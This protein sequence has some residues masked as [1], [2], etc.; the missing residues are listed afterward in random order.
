[1]QGV[2]PLRLKRETYRLTLISHSR[3][4]AHVWVD[5]G[6]SHLDGL[7]S[8]RIPDDVVESIRVGSRVKVPFNS[9]S[10]EGLVVN[11]EESDDPQTNLKLIE[12]L[13]GH[14]PV[15]NSSIINFYARMSKYWG[16][17][18]YSLIRAGI[19]SRVASVEKNFAQYTEPLEM[20]RNRIR[21]K[22]DKAFLMHKPHFSAYLELADLACGRIKNGSVLLLL[23]DVKDVE[24]ILEILKYRNVDAPIIR[25]D[26]SL[27]RS[28]RYQNYLSV[29]VAE[30]SLVVGTR[31]ALFAPANNL[32][33]IIVG[34]EK[35]EQYFEQKHPYW[36]ARD[37]A[38]LRAEVESSNIYFTGYVPSAEVAYQIE[39]RSTAF[40]RVKSSVKTFAYSQE[41]GELLPDR[42]INKI[43]Q[44]LS[45][46]K[47]LFLAPRK[48][49]ANALLCSKCKN[50]SLCKCGGRLIIQGTN[51]DPVCS[52]CS[53]KIV[54]WM[55]SWCSGKTKYAVARGIDRFHEEIGRAFPNTAIQISS[56]P[57]ILQE[58]SSKTKIVISTVGSIPGSFVDY[59]AVVILE[60]QRFLA[61][62]SSAYEEMVFESFFEASSRVKKNGSVLI[63]LDPYHPAIAA[64]SRWNPSILIKKILRECSD[65]FLPPYASTAV[66]SV[67]IL[68]GV[69][70][71]NGIAKTIKDG[72]LP[73]ISRV[74]LLEDKSK[75]VSKIFV[76]VPRKDR[77][78]LVD[79]LS[80]FA[81]KRAISK[82]SLITF[83]LDPFT[84]VY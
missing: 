36:N 42:I 11:L 63:V 75:N 39:N 80:E 72:R 40:Q 3:M 22:F 50:L 60:G 29:V 21:K 1:M 76:S 19:P 8:Y 74:N 15:A 65:A 43:R 70:L 4:V 7:Y 73:L 68:E 69:A 24:R 35:S 57:N 77:Q 49:Y 84:L 78:L 16:S 12:S 55:C 25:L 31:S 34:F 6:L 79:F 62:S 56:S 83:A 20:N 41:K 23:P 2:K 66:L 17:D 13:L 58:I 64:L 52:I 46:G 47:V 32:D 9:R 82:K 71:R 53:M 30:K 38:C 18:P 14:I 61:S 26:S 37:S 67:P 44:A 51:A 28:E 59:S 45:E 48:G 10:C 33:S 5:T 27:A 54:D 81:R